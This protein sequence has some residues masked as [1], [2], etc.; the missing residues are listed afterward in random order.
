MGDLEGE[1]GAADADAGHRDA[2]RRPNGEDRP[3][4]GD[5]ERGP[6]RPAAGQ[7]D[8]AVL[9]RRLDADDAAADQQGHAGRAQ[10]LEQRADHLVQAD[11]PGDRQPGNRRLIEGGAGTPRLVGQFEPL[12]H[13]GEGLE[14]S[15]EAVPRQPMDAA[16][17]KGGRAA[18]RPRRRLAV[19]QHRDPAAAF[20]DQIGGQQP[21]RTGADDDDVEIDGRGHRQ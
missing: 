16:G 19:A 9:P 14:A 1:G 5:A 17:E 13:V 3:V 12:D 4:G 10:A 6:Q 20:A 21:G 18:V 7:L 11:V 8:R 2:E 15:G